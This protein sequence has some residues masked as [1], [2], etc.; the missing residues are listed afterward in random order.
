MCQR[1]RFL[2]AEGG[3]AGDNG[4]IVIT[5]ARP[6]SHR[7]SS[8]SPR[9]MSRRRR[10][11]SHMRGIVKGWARCCRLACQRH[12]GRGGHRPGGSA[13]W[14]LACRASWLLA[15]QEIAWRRSLLSGSTAL[16]LQRRNHRANPASCR[17]IGTSLRPKVARHHHML[18][19]F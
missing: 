13:A 9:M 4:V 6:I 18:V 1:S 8:W 10:A 7:S 19:G 16:S 2:C 17:T 12:C 14:R 15:A 3:A 5:Q 11:E